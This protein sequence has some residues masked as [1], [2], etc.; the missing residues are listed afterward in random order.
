M[1]EI[2][3]TKFWIDPPLQLQMLGYVLA[4]LTASLLIVSYTA[5]QGLETAS[6]QSRQIFHSLEWIR[7]N[8]RGP[9]LLSSTLSILAGGVL[10]LIWSHRFAG[11]LRVLSAAMA[12]MKAGD[13]SGTVR[14]RTTDTHQEFA[15]EFASMQEGLRDL[16]ERDR[17]LAHDAARRLEKALDGLP[18][19]GEARPEL[20]KAL[21]D[22]R[23]LLS[24]L[25]T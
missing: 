22:L 12:R 2:K 20:E 6:S 4:L 14:I 9:L 13:F 1:K 3:R 15:R 18:K 11:P 17:K 19:G 5:L 10:T 25:K 16:I 8:L 7:Q 23:G 21:L 24:G